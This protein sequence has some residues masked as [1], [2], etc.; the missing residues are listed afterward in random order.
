MPRHHSYIKRQLNGASIRYTQ[1]TLCDPS[2]VQYSGYIDL[3]GGQKYF[4]WFFESRNNPSNDPFTLWLQGGPGCSSLGALFQ[5]IGPCQVPDD[6]SQ[7]FYNEYTWTSLTNILFLDQPAGAGYSK[8]TRANSTDEA[9]GLAYDFVQYFFQAFPKYSTLPF[10]IFGESYAGH[11]IPALGSYILDQNQLTT[12]NYINLISAAI[13]NGIVD[14]LEQ[15]QYDETMACNSSYGSVLPESD[16]QRMQQNT[17]AC[18]SLLEKCDQTGTVKDCVDATDF[19]SANVENIYKLSNHSIYD[20]RTT[21]NQGSP[22]TKF[23]TRPEIMKEINANGHFVR[24]AS[25]VKKQ[26][27]ATGDYARRFSPDVAKLLNNNIPVLVYAGDADYR[28][29]WYGCLGWTQ[30]LQFDG[31]DAYQASALRPW[32]VDGAEAGQTKSGGGLTFVR[33]YEAGHKVP[34]YKPVQAL[35]MI[36]NFINNQP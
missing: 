15:V 34:A 25:T 11:F 31:R 6:G 10:H 21:Q 35:Q 16:C 29:N 7:A 32:I 33:V 1:P 9:V 23:I 26:F 2:V 19:C 22:Y 18:V 20:I 27:Y 3:P 8:G 24:C 13:G 14:V 12:S 4:F 28:A 30:A 5:E 17:P 36:T